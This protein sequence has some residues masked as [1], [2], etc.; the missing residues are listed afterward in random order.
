MGMPPP[1]AQLAFRTKIAARWIMPMITNIDMNLIL[2][3]P[4]GKKF[5]FGHIK[6]RNILK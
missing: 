3:T 6:K 2:K 5:N 4:L 1:P